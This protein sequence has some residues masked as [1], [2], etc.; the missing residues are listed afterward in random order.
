MAGRSASTSDRPPG[1]RGSRLSGNLADYDADRLGFLT[2]VQQEYGDVVR[3]GPHTTIVFDSADVAEVLGGSTSFTIQQ[4][5][6]QKKLTPLE[7]DTLLPLRRAMNPGLRPHAVAD[8][9]PVVVRHLGPRLLALP[10]SD[11]QWLEPVALFEDVVSATVAE[12]V[13]GPDGPRVAPQVR[14]LLDELATVIGNPW[15]PPSW[16]R[17]PTRRRIDRKHL[18][19]RRTV[20]T[21]LEARGGTGTDLASGMATRAR[22]HGLPPERV[23]DT[24]IGALLAAQRVP[25]AAAA[26]TFLL[27]ADHPS[28]QTEVRDALDAPDPDLATALARRVVLESLRLFPPTWMVART[29]ATPVKVGG[30]EISAGH[31]VMVSPY[32]MHRDE[33][34]FDDAA[35]FRPER[36]RG[37]RPAP[38]AYLPYG[39]GVHACPGRHLATGV[40]TELVTSVLRSH[41]VTRRP[42]EV[43]ADPRTTLLPRGLALGLRPVGAGLGAEAL[44]HGL[45]GHLE[46]VADLTP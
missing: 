35:A 30:Y 38:A 22:A 28:H 18:G 34:W 37:R 1:P 46:R 19:L 3:F 39:T 36:W 13:L 43:V 25:A 32:V 9:G 7:A 41:V 44:P 24:L 27:L 10:G 20:M 2:R 17:T 23:A 33:R 29:T 16:A 4:N 14:D 26:W 6:L 12:V 8:I 31:H 45:A 42:G 15:A 5:F 21:L 11:S 40:L